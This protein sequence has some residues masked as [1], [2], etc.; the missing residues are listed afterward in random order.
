[1]DELG[2]LNGPSNDPRRRE[3][4]ARRFLTVYPPGAQGKAML[5]SSQSLAPPWLSAFLKRWPASEMM[6]GGFMRLAPYSIQVK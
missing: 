6:Q 4:A 1:V 3:S 2:G 5:R